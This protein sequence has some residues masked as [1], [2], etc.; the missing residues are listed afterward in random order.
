[1]IGCGSK[2][3]GLVLGGM[4]AMTV[5]GAWGTEADIPSRAL[6][7]S[8]TAPPRDAGVY[9]TPGGF[10]LVHPRNA[11]LPRDYTGCKSIWVMDSPDHV[12]LYVRLY[13]EQG[14]LRLARTFGRDGAPAATCA[15]LG[16]LARGSKTAS[17]LPFTSRPGRG[18][19]PRTRICRPAGASRTDAVRT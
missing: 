10:L 2:A 8:L 19:V 12:P 5:V 7:C 11:S 17:W 16:P 6:N 4:L 9:V 14:R 3:A 13:F 1:M 18:S 15:R